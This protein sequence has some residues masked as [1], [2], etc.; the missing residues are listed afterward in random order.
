MA[1]DPIKNISCS[2]GLILSAN[3]KRFLLL[4]RRHGKTADTWGFVGGKKEPKDNSSIDVLNREIEEELGQIPN[5]RKIIPLELFVSSDFKFQYNTYVIVVEDEFI[6]ILN[7]EH[8][9][10]A[11]CDYKC[12][13]KPLHQRINHSFNNKIIKAKLEILLEFI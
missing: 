7:S 1:S 8:S 3:T 9:A 11:W 2:G 6:P 5:V 10:Y 12:W 13:P 4:L